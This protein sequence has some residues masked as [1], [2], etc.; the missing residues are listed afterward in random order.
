MG[1]AS[2]CALGTSLCPR[3]RLLPLPDCHRG[4]HKTF[5]QRKI[6]VILPGSL[7]SA[8]HERRSAP[9][10]IPAIS[11]QLLCF[12]VTDDG[13]NDGFLITCTPSFF[14]KEVKLLPLDTFPH[15]HHGLRLKLDSSIICP[16]K[17]SY[18]G[19][20]TSPAS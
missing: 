17:D 19:T 20:Q 2:I 12:E 11:E 6:H 16:P 9:V 5:F 10:A 3:T 7:E 13:N 15:L 14:C 4:S 8:K 1:A 18:G